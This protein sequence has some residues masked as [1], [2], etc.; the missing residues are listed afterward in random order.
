MQILDGKTYSDE[1]KAQVKI[2]AKA[3]QKAHGAPPGL[4]VILV[5]KDPASRTYVAMKSKA[6]KQT[7]LHSEIYELEENVTQ[8]EIVELIDILNNSERI[9]GILLQLPLPKHIDTNALL[10][11][12]D[13]Q[14]DVDGFHPFNFGKMALGQESLCPCTPL[15]I[16][17][18]LKK[19][20]IDLKGKNACVVGASNIV[21]K[22]LAA[23][24]LNEGA[25]VDTC[26]ALTRDLREH[27][28]RADLVFVGVGKPGL[29]TVDMIKKGA[30]VVDIGINKIDGK[31]IGDADFDG[32][33]AKASYVT[34]VPG[35]VGPMTIAVLLQNTLNAANIRTKKYER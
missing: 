11:K 13:V 27:T 29:L 25:T 15:G 18:L 26:H 22:P 10:E 5:G 14:K 7:G 30:V 19:Y 28:L 8:E 9:D 2:G 6:C 1:I 31:I 21:G 17:M 3:F 34:P 33:C 35:G 16:I 24:L 12:I 20:G 23:M 32:I 4:A